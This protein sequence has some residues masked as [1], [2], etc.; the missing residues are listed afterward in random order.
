MQL[1]N[2]ML[3]E[4]VVVIPLAVTLDGIILWHVVLLAAPSGNSRVVVDAAWPNRVIAVITDSVCIVF[5]ETCAA[6]LA[7]A[8]VLGLIPAVLR[9]ALVL[10]AIRDD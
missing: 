3:I 10:T 9:A 7:S 1:N 4:V 6:V 5:M 8:T 2:F